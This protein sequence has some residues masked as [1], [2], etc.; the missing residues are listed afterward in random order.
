MGERTWEH[1]QAASLVLESYG[2]AE[3]GII[4]E[5]A[6]D[7]ARLTELITEYCERVDPSRKNNEE[8]EQMSSE[9]SLEEIRAC[10]DIHLLLD[11]L[12]NASFYGKRSAA[13]AAL[14]SLGDEQAIGPLIQALDDKDKDVRKAAVEALAVIG[15][16][17]VA[18][19][20]EVLDRKESSV[21]A[22]TAA[23]EALRKIDDA[24]CAEYIIRALEDD[25]AQVRWHAAFAL[26]E[27]ECQEAV[28]PLIRALADE[29]HWVR[30]NVVFALQRVGDPKAVDALVQILSD[31]SSDVRGAAERALAELKKQKQSKRKWWR[32]F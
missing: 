30:F 3:Q 1:G 5:P 23:V 2:E 26:G 31:E 29:H 14:G 10:K 13:A 19:L 8:L 24:R 17:S 15:A 11:I 21:S 20:V 22:R 12:K 28:D 16:V 25:Q 32:L 18:P 4:D 6:S 9:P 27:M 7:A